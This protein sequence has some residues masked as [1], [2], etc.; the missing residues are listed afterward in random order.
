MMQRFFDPTPDRH[1]DQY[2]V[3]DAERE[4]IERGLQAMREGRFANDD[5]MAKIFA[6]ARAARP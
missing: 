2:R 3:S 1:S 6:K 5:R 4:G